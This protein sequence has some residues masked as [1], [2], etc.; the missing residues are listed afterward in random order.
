MIMRLYFDQKV[1]FLCNLSPFACDPVR[2]KV[3]AVRSLEHRSIV[4]VGAQD[5]SRVL[6]VGIPDHVKETVRLCRA[7]DCPRLEYV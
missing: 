3:T 7:V 4:T 1:D 6:L 5:I 2:S